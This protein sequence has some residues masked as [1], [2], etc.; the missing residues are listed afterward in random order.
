MLLDRPTIVNALGRLDAQ[1]A[2]RGVRAEL[3][4]VGGAVM[5]LVHRARPSARD[6][7]DGA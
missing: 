2:A 3:L 5:C 7:D 4:L 6:V 1:L